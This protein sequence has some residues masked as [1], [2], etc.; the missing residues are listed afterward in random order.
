MGVG[1]IARVPLL[2]RVLRQEKQS[3]FLQFTVDLWSSTL[4]A[5]RE[6]AKHLFQ[7]WCKARAR[8]LTEIVA[9]VSYFQQLP[10][11]LLQMAHYDSSVAAE[12]ARQCLE[13]WKDQ[14]CGQAHRQ[15]RRFLDPDY[16]SQPGDPALRH[17]VERM[18]SLEDIRGEEF[19]PLRK[20][21]CRF[22]CIRLAERSVEGTH[23]VVTRTLKR[24]PAAQTPYISVELRFRSFWES[25]AANPLATGP[26]SNDS[27]DDASAG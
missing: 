7:D 24:A 23:A 27:N 10:W 13:L 3:S 12:G 16:P 18:A 17:L 21:L 19:L 8:V 22:A 5:D 14:D 2:P 25:I 9:K 6:S 20:W 4:K 11:K 1:H 15:T 26:E